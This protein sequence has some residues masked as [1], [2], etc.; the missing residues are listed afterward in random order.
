MEEEVGRRKEE[1]EGGELDRDEEEEVVGRGE[2]VRGEGMMT[3]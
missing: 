2:K 1:V 3:L